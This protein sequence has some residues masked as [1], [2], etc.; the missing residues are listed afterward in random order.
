[1]DISTKEL[2]YLL[3]NFWITKEENPE[4]YFKIKKK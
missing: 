4:K 1:M 2:E 3:N